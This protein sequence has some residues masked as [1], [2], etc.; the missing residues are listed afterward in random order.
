ML[1]SKKDFTDVDLHAGIESSATESYIIFKL[2]ENKFAIALTEAKRVLPVTNITPVPFTEDFIAGIF[3]F[4]NHLITVF[5]L[6]IFLSLTK[7]ESEKSKLLLLKNHNEIFGILVDEI[8]AIQKI[9]QDSIYTVDS[10]F[11][12]IS[13][14]F[15]KGIYKKEGLPESIF[16]L[17]IHGILN[18]EQ[19]KRYEKR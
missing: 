11:N 15:I 10:N 4:R 6:E 2:G 8:T 14:E 19:F 5:K 9:Q 3:N 13:K 1:E 17:S 16:V 12:I 18:A 7:T